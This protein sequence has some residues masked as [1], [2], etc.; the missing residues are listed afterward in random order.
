MTANNDLAPNEPRLKRHFDFVIAGVGLLLSLPLWAIVALAIKLDDGGPIFF[1]HERWGRHGRII[2]V[3]KFRTMV[4][5]ADRRFGPVQAGVDDPRIT[6]RGRLLRATGL[7]ELPQLLSICKGDMSLVGPRALAI[8]ETYRDGNGRTVAY[9]AVPG[10][11][12]R[13]KV[14]PGL[15]GAATIYLPKDAHPSE[16]FA[17]DVEYVRHPSLL[18]DLKLIALSLWISFRGKWE[19]RTSKF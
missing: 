9:A 15:T 12:E 11:D 16:R 2:R 7:D 17:L 1:T 13:L 3:R 19:T 4:V 6:R 10:F 14:R 18:R 8:D 5:D